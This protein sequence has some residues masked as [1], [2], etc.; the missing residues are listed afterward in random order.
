MI[1]L[2]NML[3]LLKFGQNSGSKSD[4]IPP[5]PPPPPPTTTIAHDTDAAGLQ[6][7]LLHEKN[8]ATGSNH[9]QIITKIQSTFIGGCFTKFTQWNSRRCDA[10]NLP[11]SI[12]INFV[13]SLGMHGI[14]CESDGTA[15]WVYDRSIPTTLLST[16]SQAIRDRDSTVQCLL[17]HLF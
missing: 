14:I 9:D 2:L 16:S 1:L 15:Y 13:P 5:L 4:T 8:L 3:V 6:Q 7:I 11:S 12:N 10:Q 17:Q